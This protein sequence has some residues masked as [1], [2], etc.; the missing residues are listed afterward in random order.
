ML[1]LL[2]LLSVFLLLQGLGLLL[3]LRLTLVLVTVLPS[4][5]SSRTVPGIKP[6]AITI[7]ATAKSVK[8]HDAERFTSTASAAV[9][10]T[11]DT[12]TRRTAA[13]PANIWV[14][15]IGRHRSRLGG[16]LLFSRQPTLPTSA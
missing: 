10:D 7:T 15:A 6:G 5:E 16:M 9:A 8:T 12:A 13:S 1:L 4:R 14:D 3:R 11:A 2:L